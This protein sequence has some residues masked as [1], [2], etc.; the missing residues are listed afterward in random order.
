MRIFN[1]IVHKTIDISIIRW[2]IIGSGNLSSRGRWNRNSGMLVLF[3]VDKIGV[4]LLN[5]QAGAGLGD[6]G[7]VAVADDLSLGV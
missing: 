3:W 2:G 7:E 6:V 1:K 4:D 5:I